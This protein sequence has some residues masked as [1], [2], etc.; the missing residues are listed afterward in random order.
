MKSP[1]NRLSRFLHLPREDQRVV[2]EAAWLLPVIGLQLRRQGLQA[3]LDRVEARRAEHRGEPR[4][5]DDTDRAARIA[6]LVAAVARN[7]VT[8]GSCLSR[9]MT[10]MQL[11]LR[12]GIDAELR[13][14][15]RN[16]AD[17][18]AHAWVEHMGCPLN[19]S[20]DV[21]ERYSPYPA[22]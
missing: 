2:L 9:S 7:G 15:V 12:E 5:P 4:R 6:L 17:L 20:A 18:E 22:L 13:L 10:L 8:R 19:D 11:L 16:R 3:Q 14:G 1:L 21:G